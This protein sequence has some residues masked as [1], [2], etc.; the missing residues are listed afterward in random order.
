MTRDPDIEL[1]IVVPVLNEAE[2]VLEIARRVAAVVAREQLGR[3]EIIFID[4]GSRDRSW[5]AIGEARAELG[6]SVIGIRFRKNYGKAAALSAGFQ[7]A[8]GGVVITMD[9]D[10]QDDPDEIPRLLAKLAEGFDLVSGWKR[11]RR[12]PLSKTLP[13]RLFNATTRLLSQVRLHDFNCGF[14]AY[15]AEVTEA[16]RIYGELHRYIP[17][18]AHDL[19]F[20]VAEIPVKHHPRAHGVSKYGWRRYSRGLLDLITVVAITRFLTRPAHLFGSVGVLVGTVGLGVLSYLSWLWV[21]GVRPIGTRPL[22]F[23]GILCLLLAT[24]MVSFGLLAEI[25]I[26]RLAP[27]RA[28]FQTSEVLGE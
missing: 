27:D 20:T 21:E 13:S 2:T 6:P 10:L 19:G 18:L 11:D 9:G 12:D 3:H 25:L 4:D 17:V 7:R 28:E 26:K 23:L 22:F 1:S 16:V 24:Q 5:A 15:R 14:K 8:R